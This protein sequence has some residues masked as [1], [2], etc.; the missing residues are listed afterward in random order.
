VRVSDCYLDNGDDAI[1]LKA[2]KDA[3]G[4]RVNRPTEN[5]TVTN[6]VVHRGSS[7]VVSNVACQGTQGG[8]NIKSE[9]GRGGGLEDIWIDNLTM[10]NVGRA[11]SISQYY[12]MQGERPS[13]KEPASPAHARV[14]QYCDQ[15]R[16]H[17]PRARVR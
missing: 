8:I 6:T 7:C 15:P 2:G 17:Q 3:D 5:V 4:L 9:R 14:S 10:E 11:I 16:D 12:T 13:L 1:T